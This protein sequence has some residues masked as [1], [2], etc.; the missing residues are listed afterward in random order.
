MRWG[1]VREKIKKGENKDNYLFEWIFAIH[2]IVRQI[3][4]KK[5]NPTIGSSKQR[6]TAMLK[7]SLSNI[8]GNLISSMIRQ[9]SIAIA[10]IFNHLIFII[11]LLSK[12]IFLKTI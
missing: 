5:A 11:W 3:K 2:I 1:A 10:K 9:I 8:F 12:M 7:D 6:G 4:P